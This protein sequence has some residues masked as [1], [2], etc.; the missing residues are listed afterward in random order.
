MERPWTQPQI[1]VIIPCLN[2]VRTIGKVVEG[3]AKVLPDADIFVY[4]NGSSDGTI[5]I[6]KSLNVQLR[7]VS[8]RG[9]GNV[10]RS[11]FADVEADI[12]L[13]VDGDNTYDPAVAP[14]LISLITDSQ[15]DL[16]T[17]CRIRSDFDSSARRGHLVGNRCFT[18]LV[19]VLFRTPTHDVLSGYRVMTRRFVKS[20]P[21][22]SNGFEI[23]VQIA[24]H[25]SMLRVKEAS[26]NSLYKERSDSNSKL[27]TFTDGRRI[28]ISIL[29]LYRSAEPSRFFGSLS[30]ICCAMAAALR[31]QI[32]ADAYESAFWFFMLIAVLLFTIGI[33]LNGISRIQKQNVRLAFLQIPLEVKKQ[34]PNHQSEFGLRK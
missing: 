2:E 8:A 27:R 32:A 24:A 33:T 12:Y 17:G 21:T 7:H 13:L 3:F 5:Q 34:E 25:A 20:F 4:D 23:E 1:A 26:I 28:L 6:A 18:R 11:A 31:W 9:K 10:V 14:E 29:R 19:Q 30:F 22:F 15:C 16:V